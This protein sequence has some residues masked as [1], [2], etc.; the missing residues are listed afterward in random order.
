M[1]DCVPLDNGNCHILLK[2]CGVSRYTTRICKD[3]GQKYI[4]NK[5]IGEQIE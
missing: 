3:M 1:G 2:S 4:E 5:R